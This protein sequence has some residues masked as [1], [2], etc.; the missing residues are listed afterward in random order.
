MKRMLTLFGVLALVAAPAIAN[1]V[2]LRETATIPQTPLTIYG[3]N[4]LGGVGG[5]VGVYRFDVGAAGLTT[6]PGPT[7][8]AN[9]WG[10]CI[11]MQYS[12]T[13]WN[14]YNIVDLDA[15]PNTQGDGPGA[16]GTMGTGKADM[17]AALWAQ[18]I[19]EAVDANGNVVD[20]TSAS[21]FQAA[22][23]EIVYENTG[24][25]DVGAW[26]GTANSFK[27]GAYG[28]NTAVADAV[29]N[30]AN[31]WLSTLNLNGPKASLLAYSNNSYQDYAFA[32]PAPGAALLAVFGLSIL[33]WIKRRCA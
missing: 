20:N 28:G 12:S 24:T 29:I 6:P 21:A 8:W 2:D 3:K 30:K 11:E 27:I 9:Q 7:T 1:V 5:Y 15:A 16:G 17:L 31:G 33:G 26:N 25:L 19:S 14:R 32:V 10:F 4:F 23:W 18:H 22:V 13:A